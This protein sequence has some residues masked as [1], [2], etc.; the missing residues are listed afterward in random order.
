M[1]KISTDYFAFPAVNSLKKAYKEYINKNNNPYLQHFMPEEEE[2]LIDEERK[3]VIPLSKEDQHREAE[4]E[5][6]YDNDGWFDELVHYSPL[7]EDVTEVIRTILKD[8]S[9]H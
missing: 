5:L 8:F 3:I 7:R 2:L 6:L 9:C 4:M 1:N